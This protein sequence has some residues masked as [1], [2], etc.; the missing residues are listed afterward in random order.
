M[1]AVTGDNE[2]VVSAIVFR[3]LEFGFKPH[4]DAQFAGALLQQ[5]QHGLAPDAG[6]A[7]A[8]G[9]GALAI[10]NDGDIIPVGKVAADGART[11]RIVLLHAGQCVI[12][13][14]H[15]PAKRV[16]G[17]I[18]LQHRHLMGGIAQLHRNG[19][20]ESGWATA[21]AKYVHAVRL[22]PLRPKMRLRLSENNFKLKIS[23]LKF[24]PGGAS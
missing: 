2:V 20:V 5:H 6:E 1:N 18:S 16:V 7:M 23:D 11:F 4:V 19:E 22:F 17:T 8:T 15:P 3:R 10:V 13:Q 14:H 9:H 21:K 12:G 24:L